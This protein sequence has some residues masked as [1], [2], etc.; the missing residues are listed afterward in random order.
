MFVNLSPAQSNATESSTSLM[1]GGM[2]KEIKNDLKKNFE[3]KEME[4]MKVK[5]KQLES[6]RLTM[7]E[8]MRRAN[9][10]FS[11]LEERDSFLLESPSISLYS[12]QK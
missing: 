6:E 7:L 9:V 5:I 8:A 12:Q 4:K 2:V 10:D 11:E 1:Y 3:S